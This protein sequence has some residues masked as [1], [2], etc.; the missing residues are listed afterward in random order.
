M[1]H[2]SSALWTEPFPRHQE[3]SANKLFPI[4][5]TTLPCN[6][7]PAFNCMGNLDWFFT[8][9]NRMYIIFFLTLRQHCKGFSNG[10]LVKRG[11]AFFSSLWPRLFLVPLQLPCW[12]HNKFHILLTVGWKSLDSNSESINVPI[13]SLPYLRNGYHALVLEDF[14]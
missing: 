10:V 13:P 6:L 14:L 8:A 7:P 1:K 11:L 3:P 12:N 4:Y 2:Y 9:H 5:H